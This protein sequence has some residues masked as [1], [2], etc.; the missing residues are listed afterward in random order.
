MIVQTKAIVLKQH[1]I[2]NNRRLIVLFTKKYGK[3]SAGTNMNE[4]RRGKS[5]LA[6]RPFAYSDF[7]L[8]KKGSYYSINYSGGAA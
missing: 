2:A 3:I 4:G 7:E 8:Y 6:L 1:K 5:A